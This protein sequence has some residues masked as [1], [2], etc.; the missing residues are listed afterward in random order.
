[1]RAAL[2]SALPVLVSHPEL[3]GS[4]PGECALAQGQG[5]MSG[6]NP[7]AAKFMPFKL[8]SGVVLFFVKKE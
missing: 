7:A 1:M 3:Q 5:M 8:L 6:R 2:G 4:L